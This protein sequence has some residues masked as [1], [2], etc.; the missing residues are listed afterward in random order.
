MKFFRVIT[1]AI[2]EWREA[3]EYL[4]TLQKENEAARETLERVERI[5]DANMTDQQK[6]DVVRLLVQ[7]MELANA[8]LNIEVRI[9]FFGTE[10]ILSGGAASSRE[11]KTDRSNRTGNDQGNAT[12]GT[13]EKRG[14]ERT[15]N[16]IEPCTNHHVYS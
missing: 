14:T 16:K 9:L 2:R 6:L 1:Q 8:K 15:N 5:H 12:G 7:N 3:G 11:S 13:T 10:I 4:A